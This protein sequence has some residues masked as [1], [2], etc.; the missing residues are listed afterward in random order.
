MSYE[1]R[2]NKALTRAVDDIDMDL[3]KKYAAY[4][5]IVILVFSVNFLSTLGLLFNIRYPERVIREVTADFFKNNLKK[6]VKFD[7][8]FI[9]YNG[10]VQISN[11]DMSI[12]SDFNDNVSL[13]KCKKVIV[14]LDFLR[15]FEGRIRV[16]GLEFHNSEITYPKKY[17]RSH[18][19]SFYQVFDVDAIHKRVKESYKKLYIYFN[20]AAIHY[21]ESLRDKQVQIDLYK[22]DA[23]INIEGHSASYWIDGFIKTHKTEN[24]RRGSIYFKGEFDLDKE[25][26]WIHRVKIDNFDLTYLNSYL[27]EF[28]LLNISLSGGWSCDLE[29]AMKNGLGSV[30][31]QVETNNLTVTDLAKKFN[32]ISNENLNFEIDLKK[33]LNLNRYMLSRLHLYDDVFS[34][35]ASGEYL[36]NEKDETLIFRYNTNKIDLSDL[37]KNLTPYDHI[38]LAG[39][40]SSNGKFFFDFKKGKAAGSTAVLTIDDFSL[41][42]NRKGKEITLID[43]SRVKAELTESELNVDAFLKPLESDLAIKARA[44]ISNWFPFKSDS[45]V[46]VTSKKFNS[47]IF[48]HSAVYGMDK[49][50]AASYENKK[51]IDD[52][53]GFLNKPAAIFLN[54]NNIGL[55]CNLDSILIGKRAKVKD[56]AFD[57]QLNKGVLVLREFGAHGCD[58]E[59]KMSAQAFFNTEQPYFKFEGRINNLDL[60]ELFRRT[61]F[62]GKVSGKAV[63][64][65]KYELSANRISDFLENSKGSFS[66]NVTG[67][68]M[69]KCHPQSVLAWFLQKNGYPSS[70]IRAVSFETLSVSVTQLGER[71]WFTNF[72]LKGDSFS[73]NGGGEY[74][75]LTGLTGRLGITVKNEGASIVVPVQLDGPLL[76]PCINLYDKK[77]S[78][79]SCF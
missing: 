5:F 41:V 72:G 51:I 58:A 28:K 32:T 79:K 14:D 48:F 62:K 34:I 7:D 13:I 10:N 70:S 54:N 31:G 11:F 35:K 2:E 42:N 57:M 36:K 8:I 78:Q 24:I 39:T 29:F 77:G 59:Y 25:D 30:K 20:S 40:L 66:L 67:G 71:F 22:L 1:V 18:I 37:S 17:G 12:S 61:G 50:M 55:R 4:V 63:I 46:T 73:F 23:E 68:T 38:G 16:N 64:D 75:Y 47:E 33:D 15:L 26:L 27:S 6:A 69:E 56:L 74:S 49:L 21:Q 44:K 43:D 9:R 3:K 65:Y 76:S 45:V 19:D 60:A 53:P 52:I